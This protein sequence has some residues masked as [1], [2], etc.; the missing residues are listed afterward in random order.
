MKERRLGRGLSGLIHRTDRKGAVDAQESTA[1]ARREIPEIKGEQ[2]T[3]PKPKAQI[4]SENGASR[5]SATHRAPAARF[6]AIE[7]IRPNP[8][9]PRASMDDDELS[10]LKHSIVTHGVLQPLLVRTIESGYELIAGERRLRAA[11]AA[12]LKE[13]P[14]VVKAASEED[15][16]T[17][18]LVENIQRVDLN[19]IEKAVALRTMMSNLGITQGNVAKRVGKARSTIANLLRLLD[20]P[21]PVLDLVR[22]DELSE[23]HARALL[24]VNGDANRIAAA[25]RAVREGLSVRALEQ[26]VGGSATGKKGASTRRGPAGSQEGESTDVYMEDIRI[27][28]ERALGTAVRVRRKGI[29]GEIK[30]GFHDADDLDRLL[31]LFGA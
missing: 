5:S 11:T 19:A 22:S 15:M 16:Q 8:Y 26:I 12:G 24:R 17:L 7:D 4:D 6:A 28:L 10:E 2:K 23:G 13:V 27:R 29:G 31:T 1:P 25:D 21:T 30:I 20:L 14:V 3:G 18:A 9:Q